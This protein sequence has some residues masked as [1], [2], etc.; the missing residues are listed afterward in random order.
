[1]A[2]GDFTA[3]GEFRYIDDERAAAANFAARPE[4][5]MFVGHTHQPCVWMLDEMGLVTM[6]PAADFK[7]LP[8]R[9]YI[10]NPGTVLALFLLCFGAHFSKFAQRCQLRMQLSRGMIFGNVQLSRGWNL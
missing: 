6:L 4:R 10:I 5:I 9:R 1:M 8:N 7:L 2:H 3:P